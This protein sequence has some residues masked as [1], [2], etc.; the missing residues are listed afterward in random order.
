MLSGCTAG[1]DE[2]SEPT[3]TTSPSGHSQSRQISDEE[4]FDR[5]KADGQEQGVDVVYPFIGPENA[6]SPEY[7]DGG[8]RSR[9][10]REAGVRAFG[11][12]YLTLVFAG[13]ESEWLEAA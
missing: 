3:Q 8:D 10:A 6:S 11:D 4:A 1:R 2:Q 5:L 9:S 7:M 12:E 13:W